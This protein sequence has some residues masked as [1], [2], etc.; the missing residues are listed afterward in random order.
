MSALGYARQL[1]LATCAIG[2]STCSTQEPPVPLPGSDA[3]SRAAALR[4]C[5]GNPIAATNDRDFLFRSAEE[6]LLQERNV[7]SYLGDGRY[8]ELTQT[9]TMVEYGLL[10]GNGD[11]EVVVT[12]KQ[13]PTRGWGVSGSRVC[14]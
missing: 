12:V 4:G 8:V 14:E 7:G 5:N 1:L 10:S 6:A 11:L 13:D 3:S 9:M 2:L